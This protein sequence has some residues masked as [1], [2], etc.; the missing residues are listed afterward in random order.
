MSNK[1]MGR[2][3][4]METKNNETENRVRFEVNKEPERVAREVDTRKR[5][6]F[7]D[8]PDFDNFD[9][10]NFDP[11]QIN[12]AAPPPR[13]DEKWGKMRQHWA[14]HKHSNGRRV[15]DLMSI[16][17]RVRR[18][19]TVP[20]AF[21]SF[22]EQWEMKDVIMVAGEHVLMEIPESHWLKMQ[23]TK[24]EKNVS[25]INDIKQSHG[26]IIRTDGNEIQEFR[27]TSVSR[28]YS[29]TQVARDEN[30]DGV[31]FKE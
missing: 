6:D 4:R 30:S 7:Y 22:T 15:Q 10:K 18:P 8:L 2:P 12:L 13:I 21:R 17:Y 19:E 26:R 14:A 27:D 9:Y 31:A 20:T 25:A 16:G 24:H 23:R 1:R 29:E 3:P 5:D 28:F 11:R